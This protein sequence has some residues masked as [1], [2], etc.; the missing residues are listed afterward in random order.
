VLS[1]G[2]MEIDLA[3][4]GGGGYDAIVRGG[5]FGDYA[6][7]FA[8][9]LLQMITS[10]PQSHIEA[11]MD[12]SNRVHAVTIASIEANSY[13]GNELASDIMLLGLPALSIGFGMHLSPCASGDCALGAVVDHCADRVLDADESDVDCGGSCHACTSPAMCRTGADCDSGACDAGRCVAPTCNDGVR[14]GFE[15]GVD[16][17]FTCP[18]TC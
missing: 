2:A 5:A 7:T 11:M 15:S 1:V 8:S 16:C 14:D 17:G 4:D 13:F 9:G 12:L 18:T 3:P 6:T 10:N